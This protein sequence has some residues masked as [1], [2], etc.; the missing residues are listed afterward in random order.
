MVF[1]IIVSVELVGVHSVHRNFE[2]VNCVVV[3]LSDVALD[4]VTLVYF[5]FVQGESVLER[6]ILDV[7]GLNRVLPMRCLFIVVSFPDELGE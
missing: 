2:V 1:D 7:A 3:F 4:I 5:I 6:Y